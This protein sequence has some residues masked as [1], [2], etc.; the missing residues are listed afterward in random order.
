MINKFV[1]YFIIFT[2][3]FFFGIVTFL[4]FDS[5]FRRYLFGRTISAY[6]L[7]QIIALQPY[8]KGDDIEIA[9]SHSRSKYGETYFSFVNGQ[10]TTQGGTHQGA[11]REAIVKTL[12]EFYR[13]FNFKPEDF[14]KEISKI[15]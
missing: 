13:K 11:F 15:Y 3:L 1:K 4:T 9:L 12:R 2:I 8:L 14:P 7:Y 5:D 6:K 10:H